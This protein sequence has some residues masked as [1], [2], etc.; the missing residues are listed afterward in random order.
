LP[1][2]DYTQ[3]YG[4]NDAGEVVGYSQIASTQHAIEWK[5]GNL[6]NLGG[7][8]G[9]SG[10]VATA[11]NAAGQV[12]GYSFFGSVSIATEWSDGV[13]ISL[14]A[15]P[16]SAFSAGTAIN[17]LGAA[18]GESGFMP[19]VPPRPVPEPS[20]WALTLAGF[21]GAGLLARR[22]RRKVAPA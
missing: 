4:I 11:I 20:T 7:L 22:R 12:V 5:S 17:D 15:Q 21:A 13:V 18:V 9:A 16:G 8:P 14:E 3:A 2:A 1:G 10:S 6:I 19:F